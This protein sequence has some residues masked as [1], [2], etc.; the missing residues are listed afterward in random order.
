MCTCA[1]TLALS[2]PRVLV[3]S[4][5][6][7][8]ARLRCSRA[9]A[10]ADRGHGGA[11]RAAPQASAHGAADTRARPAPGQE[12]RLLQH[13]RRRAQQVTQLA[14]TAVEHFVCFAVVFFFFF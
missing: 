5:A 3:P 10:G 2:P 1:R 9:A 14:F 11:A 4:C 7:G 8:G 13:P 12:Q 6:G